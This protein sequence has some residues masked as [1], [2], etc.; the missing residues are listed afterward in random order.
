MVLWAACVDGFHPPYKG[1]GSGLRLLQGFG[2]RTRLL[3]TIHVLCYDLLAES[4][5]STPT[6]F[7]QIGEKVESW[8]LRSKRLM[9][10]KEDILTAVFSN[11]ELSTP[12]YLG[13]ITTE[14]QADDT[15]NLPL[16][17]AWN[18][19]IDAQGLMRISYSINTS[20]IGSM[21]ERVVSRADPQFSQIRDDIADTI[22]GI[23]YRSMI[24]TCQL[25]NMLP[26]V[27]FAPE[28]R[29]QL[30]NR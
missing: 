4:R 29:S 20:V 9:D 26:S 24:K 12:F 28:N 15:T 16:L 21:L 19:Q 14:Q 6:H 10:V 3:R 23:T 13:E 1:L 30:L 8:V 22:R 17:Y 2:F 11:K 7:D 18:E 25:A 5:L 27:V